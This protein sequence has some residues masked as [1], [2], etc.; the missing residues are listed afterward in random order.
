VGHAAVERHERLR[1]LWANGTH[2][3]RFCRPRDSSSVAH[4]SEHFDL[5]RPNHITRTGN[6]ASGKID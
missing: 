4:V 3:R 1:S 5:K 6:G 2:L